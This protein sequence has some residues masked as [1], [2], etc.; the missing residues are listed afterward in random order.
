M[1]SLIIYINDSSL[2]NDTT[3]GLIICNK[4]WMRLHMKQTSENS[5]TSSILL[6]EVNCNIEMTN[7]RHIALT[8]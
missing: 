6:C 2:N 7:N 8:H 3:A 4:V 1:F 5:E